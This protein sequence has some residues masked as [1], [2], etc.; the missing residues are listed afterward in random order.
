M[1]GSS[2]RQVPPRYP[3]GPETKLRNAGR[4]G[5]ALHIRTGCGKVACEK[6]VGFG[7]E[8]Y[9]VTMTTIAA[10]RVPQRSMWER[11]R[12]NSSAYIGT[13]SSL[14]MTEHVNLEQT[15]GETIAGRLRNV[16]SC[17]AETTGMGVSA[18]YSKSCS[19]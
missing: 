3:T 4:T 6:N 17:C 14:R 11:R 10:R 7:E 13:P 9:P 5:V 19:K 16:C 1:T 12:V 18:S 2:T 15:A 8:P